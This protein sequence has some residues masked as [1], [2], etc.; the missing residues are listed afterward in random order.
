M[1]IDNRRLRQIRLE[2]RVYQDR[3]HKA[4]TPHD[5]QIYQGKLA[6]LNREEKQILK[7][8]GVEV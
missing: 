2:K 8:Y 5:K 7:R 6:C 1:N 3:I 4:E